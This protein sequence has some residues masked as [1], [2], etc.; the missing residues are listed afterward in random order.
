MLTVLVCKDEWASTVPQDVLQSLPASEISRQKYS[1]LS[2]ISELS[3]DST[4]ASFISS[5]V[6]KSSTCGTWIP[7]SRSV[8][9]ASLLSCTCLI[10]LHAV[11]VHSAPAKYHP[12]DH[13]PERARRVHR[14][15]LREH[16]GVARGQPPPARAPRRRAELLGAEHGEEDGAARRAER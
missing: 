13:T 12:A 15:V 7:W 3:I 1:L 16:P 5:S 11:A 2:I 4:L 10:E 8:I 9:P 14:G 6:V